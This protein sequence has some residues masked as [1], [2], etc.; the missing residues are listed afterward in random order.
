MPLPA[1]LFQSQLPTRAN[2]VLPRSD[3]NYERQNDGTCALVPGLSPPDP[4]QIC[5]DDPNAIEY[6][7]VTGY[8]R[9]PITTCRGGKQM[10]ALAWHPCPGHEDEYREKRGL[11]GLGLFLAV[12][13]PVAAAAAVGYWVWRSW[14]GKFGRIRLGDAAAAGLD[15]ERPWVKWPVAAVSGL[16]AVLAAVP[17]LAASLWRS[18]AG[19]VG[20]GYGGPTYTSRSSFARGRGDYAVVDPDEG[21]LLGEDSD[22]EV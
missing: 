9:I 6:H 2:R 12:A 22:E 1:R 20:G 21:E 13:A 11:S 15:G 5:K 3:Y 19:R 17:L 18:V 7:E 14:D 10:D 16:V 4:M 8:R